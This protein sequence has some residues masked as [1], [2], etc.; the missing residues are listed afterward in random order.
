MLYFWPF[1]SMVTFCSGCH[2]SSLTEHLLPLE[3]LARWQGPGLEQTSGTSLVSHTAGRTPKERRITKTKTAYITRNNSQRSQMFCS[4]LRPAWRSIAILSSV[5]SACACADNVAYNSKG[6]VQLFLW[7]SVPLLSPRSNCRINIENYHIMHLS[8]GI[9]GQIPTPI[10][11][12]YTVEVRGDGG[13]MK[14]KVTIKSLQNV[15]ARGPG[16]QGTWK[17]H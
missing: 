7:N 5:L 1:I 14:I 15:L 12:L 9:S 17:Q 11:R 4:G 8:C 10:F 16:R 2:G 13:G 3:L 6:C